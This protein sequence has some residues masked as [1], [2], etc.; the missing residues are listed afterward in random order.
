MRSTLST[1]ELRNLRIVAEDPFYWARVLVP[2]I[3][4]REDEFYDLVDT[5]E[6]PLGTVET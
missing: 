5:Y 1:D 2:E 3:K 6:A 4:E